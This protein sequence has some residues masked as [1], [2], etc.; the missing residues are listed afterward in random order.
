MDKYCA[1]PRVLY[2]RIGWLGT[3]FTL[4]TVP[5]RVY[6]GVE[7]SDLFGDVSYFHLVLQTLTLI[8]HLL[9]FSFYQLQLFL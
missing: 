7:V 5:Y 3:L 2:C 4:I 8:L 9:P 6:L 1:Y